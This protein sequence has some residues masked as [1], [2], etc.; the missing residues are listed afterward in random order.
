MGYRPGTMIL[1]T[2]TMALGQRLMLWSNRQDSIFHVAQKFLSQQDASLARVQEALSELEHI[3][4]NR[5]ALRVKL[6]D[7]PGLN[8]AIAD[9]HDRMWIAT[10]K[11]RVG[12]P[13]RPRRSRSR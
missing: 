9:L 13:G 11:G 7:V 10:D 12:N 2:G 4:M 1:V 3:H 8:R 5:K 6:I